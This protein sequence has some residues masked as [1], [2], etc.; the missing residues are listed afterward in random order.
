MAKAL[1]ITFGILSFLIFATIIGLV[2]F[3][4][5]FDLNTYKAKIEKLVFEQTGRTLAI[6]GNADIKLSLIP[7]IELSELS[8][9]NASWA[10]DEDMLQIKRAEVSLGLLPLLRKDI[11]IEEIVLLEPVVNLA[12]NA[13][14]QGNWVFESPQD[15]TTV[16]D[17]KQNDE[18]QTAQAAGAPLAFSIVAKQLYIENGAVR[19]VDLKSKTTT[20]VNIKNL[21]LT[22]QDMDSQINLKYDVSYNGD[23]IKGNITADSINTLLKNEPYHINLNANAFGT[24]LK[25]GGILSDL[26]GDL[27]FDL[28]TFVSS[29]QGNFDLPKIDLKAKAAGNLNLINIALEKLDMGGNVIT[30][31]IKA[32][33]S[34]KKP[35]VSANISSKVFDLTLLSTPKKTASI[36]LITS[37]HAAT[38][39]PD[40]K[41]D[42]SVLN[43]LNANIKLNIDQLILTEDIDLQNLQTTIALQSGI[44]NLNPLSAVAGGGEITGN[45][46]LNAS[47]NDMSLNLNGQNIIVQDFIKSLQPKKDNFSIVSGGQTDLHVALKSSGATYQN[48]VQNLSGQVLLVVGQ[49]RLQAGALKYLRGN[50]ITQL[51]S[52][53]QLQAK[54]PKMSMKCAVLRGDFDNGKITLPKGIAFDSKKMTIVGDGT[55]NLKNDK[56]DIAIKPFNGSLTDVNV[57]QALSSLV[58]IG[59]TIE[60]PAIKL[61]NASVVKNVVGVAMTGPVFI[62]SQLLLDADPAPC[63]TALKDTKFSNMFEAPKGVKSTTQNVY[64]GTS[65]VVENGVDL[66]TGTAGNVVEGGADLIGGTA[67]GVFNLITGSSKKK[68]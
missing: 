17:K 19:Y 23:E 18:Q 62:G 41:L 55:I 27:S 1:K 66:I 15:E 59:G 3:I 49:S 52:T 54:D 51:L 46:S 45:L 43:A 26:M 24:T 8:L 37:A 9:S 5:N 39:V 63:Y 33:I 48:I 12:V 61:D 64:Q 7:T 47:N 11:E 29:P 31:K 6:K 2:I 38:F 44:L 56:L 4:Q 22:A 67:K 53:L 13:Q 25:V 57:A 60:N 10:T 14:G 21:D 40:E 58:K 16:S 32:D 20:K 50:F 28:S 30:A 65:D 36:N 34:G 68:K 42:L 35:F